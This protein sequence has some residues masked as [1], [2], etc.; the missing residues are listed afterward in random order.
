MQ[1]FDFF[2]RFVAEVDLEEALYK[3]YHLKGRDEAE[4]DEVRL[5]AEYI[6]Q[7]RKLALHFKDSKESRAALIEGS[8]TIEDAVQGIFPTSESLMVR[9]NGSRL[10]AAELC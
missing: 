7:A 6:R 4:Q 10:I 2:I 8:L 5:D 1:A 9:I 3:K